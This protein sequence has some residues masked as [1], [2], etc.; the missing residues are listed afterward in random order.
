MISHRSA[1]CRLVSPPPLNSPPR[2][3]AA[4]ST[5][6]HRFHKPAAL[7]LCISSMSK[8]GCVHSFE[9]LKA[10]DCFANATSRG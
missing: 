6:S 5:G 1:Y 3:S 4:V 8:G 9:A 7:A 2:T 10:C